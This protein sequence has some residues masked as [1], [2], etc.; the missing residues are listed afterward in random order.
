[1][2]IIII[3]L[4][5][6]FGSWSAGERITGLSNGHPEMH[7]RTFSHGNLGIVHAD[8][9]GAVKCEAPKLSFGRR[10]RLSPPLITVLTLYPQSL[11]E[12][13]H[14]HGEHPGSR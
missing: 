13:R 9:S 2:L 8:N 6:A 7:E 4:V 3:N 5:V 14:A 12:A 1:M 10:P 11:T